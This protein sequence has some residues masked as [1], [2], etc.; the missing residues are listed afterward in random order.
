MTN[1]ANLSNRDLMVAVINGLTFEVSNYIDNTYGTWTE[2]FT[3]ATKKIG[4]LQSFGGASNWTYCSV[5]GNAAGQWGCECDCDHE[6]E[7]QYN[8]FLNSDLVSH[9]RKLRNKGYGITIK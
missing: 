5:C 1:T 2:Y 8:F 3:P 9:L 4:Y 7:N 6:D